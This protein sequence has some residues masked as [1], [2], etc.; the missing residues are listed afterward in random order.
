MRTG[1]AYCSTKGSSSLRIPLCRSSRAFQV[2]SAFDAT[3]VVMAIPV[4][5]TSGNPFPVVSPAC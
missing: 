5:T 4:T 3:D 1:N 2:S